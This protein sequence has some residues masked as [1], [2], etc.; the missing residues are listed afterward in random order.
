MDFIL[1]NLQYKGWIL[2]PRRINLITLQTASLPCKYKKRVF[3]AKAGFTA[4]A[5]AAAA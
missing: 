5:A 4:L 3:R 1:S 2:T